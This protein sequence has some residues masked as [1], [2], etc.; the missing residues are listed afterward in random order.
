M[1]EPPAVEVGVTRVTREDAR[2]RRGNGLLGGADPGA[3]PN[4]M[5]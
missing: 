2:R 3:E 5:A 4:I 1:N